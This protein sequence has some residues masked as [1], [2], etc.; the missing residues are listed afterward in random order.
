VSV[1]LMY[2]SIGSGH[3]GE[4]IQVR[5]E[6][7]ARQLGWLA[8][9]GFR[10]SSLRDAL[11]QPRKKI[12]AIT[13][14]DG[15]ADVFGIAE[16]LLDAAIPPT[17]FVCPGL[18]GGVSSWT[19]SPATRSLPLL[20]PEQVRRLSGRGVQIAPHGWTHRPFTDLQPPELAGDLE[21]CDRFFAEHLGFHPDLVAYPYGRCAAGQ[22]AVV[23]TFYEFGIAVD[24]IAGIERRYAVPRVAGLEASTRE[25]FCRQLADYSLETFLPQAEV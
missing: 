25:Q 4:P 20:R 7:L 18:L 5:P 13:F 10:F 22:A 2:H 15:F 12:A 3:P 23:A 19:T 16:R 8:D 17:L 14:D 9:E 24:P 6:T 21:K 11:T 1:I